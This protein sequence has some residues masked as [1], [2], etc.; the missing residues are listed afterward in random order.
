VQQRSAREQRLRERF[1]DVIPPEYAA[2]LA[3]E[4]F[5]RALL[6]RLYE[7]TDLP[8]GQA[9]FIPVDRLAGIYIDHTVE[10]PDGSIRTRLYH[11]FTEAEREQLRSTQHGEGMIAFGRALPEGEKRVARRIEIQRGDLLEGASNT[12]GVDHVHFGGKGGKAVVRDASTYHGVALVYDRF[13]EQEPARQPATIERL[14]RRTEKPIDPFAGMS[15]LSPERRHAWEQN[16]HTEEKQEEL[17]AMRN[18]F[19]TAQA[20]IQQEWG[21]WKSVQPQYV[22]RD[23]G[24]RSRYAAM[25]QETYPTP[26]A[27]A[28]KFQQFF[29]AYQRWLIDAMLTLDGLIIVERAA[30]ERAAS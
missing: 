8:P 2:A 5:D 4:R 25:L 12:I 6:D 21:S 22:T 27:R 24:F 18:G 14:P 23:N 10:Q 7:T 9:A 11:R 28:E 1:G 13:P 20:M 17:R 16:A 15:E 26:Q 29:E 19:S 3:G 30:P